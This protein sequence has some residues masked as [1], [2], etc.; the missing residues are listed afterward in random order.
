MT[1]GYLIQKVDEI[2]V[3]IG[4]DGFSA[5]A[6]AEQLAFNFER[7]RAYSLY[8]DLIAPHK[9]AL[10]GKRHLYYVSAGALTS[11]PPAV[12]VTEAPKGDDSDPIAMSKTA[13]LGRDYAI[14][15]LPAPSSLRD[16]SGRAPSAATRPLLG[17]GNACTG[18]GLKDSPTPPEDVCGIR[19]DGTTPTNN[20]PENAT[21][22]EPNTRAVAKRTFAGVN[23]LNTR[24]AGGLTLLSPTDL[25]NK[26]SYLPGTR[27]EL[28]QL[29]AAVGADPERD[30]WLAKNAKESNLRAT[31]SNLTDRRI[32]AFSTHGLVATDGIANLEEP[33]L[34]LTPPNS[35][36]LTDDGFLAASE[37]AADLKLDAD[38]V[39]LS[40]CNTASPS[41][42]G[43]ESLSGL[44]RAF[45]YA[46][47]RSL[48]VTHWPV[49]DEV[50]ADIVVSTLQYHADHP[51]QGRAEALRQ[52]VLP[53]MKNPET[54][55]P[56]FWAPFIMVGQNH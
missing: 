30:L 22:A 36:S 15:V 9:A 10:K 5:D 26:L 48:L 32:I 44:A 2:R 42:A 21:T 38:W 12:F 53:I 35:A 37:I 46:G 40:A 4:V 25:R 3:N 20:E 33:G 50:A 14:T 23:G 19:P 28:L 54:A 17:I 13:W 52:A 41:R 49:V 7:E 24:T 45:F 27:R 16:L 55:D 34:V 8:Q 47:A 6:K 29:A 31:D 39:I 18:W 1:G 56:Y 51:K 43:A 11:L